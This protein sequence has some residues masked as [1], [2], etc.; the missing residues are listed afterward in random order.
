MQFP[1]KVLATLRN[2]SRG[3]RFP[4]CKSLC[5][6]A[7]QPDRTVKLNVTLSHETQQLQWQLNCIAKVR[8]ALWPCKRMLI[9]VRRVLTTCL[10]T[11]H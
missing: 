6:G 1:A 9:T 7:W 10:L 8:K 4:V 2:A 5:T 11:A 3:K